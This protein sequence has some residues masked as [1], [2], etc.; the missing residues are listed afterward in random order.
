MFTI[1][2][3]MKYFET[4]ENFDTD[5]NFV[6][7]RLLFYLLWLDKYYFFSCSFRTLM[8]PFSPNTSTSSE[9]FTKRIF[10]DVFYS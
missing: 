6:A 9:K 2:V 5:E 4:D 7:A 10:V 3:S 1:Q 8:G